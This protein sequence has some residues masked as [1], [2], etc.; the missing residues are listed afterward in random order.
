[1]RG[2]AG[3]AAAGRSMSPSESSR[4]AA[5]EALIELN[6]PRP[7]R[8]RYPIPEAEFVRVKQR[9]RTA[10]VARRT[11]PHAADSGRKTELAVAP[12]ASRA[13]EAAMEPAAAP[14]SS[15]NFA[16]IPATGWIPPDC[17]MAVGPNHILLSVNSSLAIYS[18]TGGPALLQR[19]LTQWFSNA[20]QDL[21]IFDPKAL[22]DQHAGRWVLLAV[23]FRQNPNRSVFLLSVSAGSDPLGSWRNY[24][25]DAM[26][27]GT[28]ATNNWADYPG[29]GVDAQALYVT[30][31]MF[32]FGGNFQYAKIRVIPKAGPY[33]GGPAPF[34][35]FVRMRNP[36]NTM[37]FTIQP[38]HTFGAPMVEYLVN[39][40]FP[41]GSALTLWRI[42]NPVAPTLTRADVPIGAYSLPP[43]ADQTGGPPELNTGDVRILHA[44]FRGDS[45]WAAFTT[46]RNWGAGNRASIHWVQIRAASNSLVQQGI[47]GARDFH[48]FYPAACPDNNGNMTLV[49]SRSGTSQSGS[50][51]FTG[52][53]ATD[54][55]GQLQ[56]SALLKT[57]VAH[58]QALDG[59]GRN[60]WGDYNGVAADP[61]NPRVIWFYSEFASAVNTWATWVGSVFF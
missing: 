13:F 36:D 41:S 34:F 3:R 55:A 14:V 19:T 7:Y 15:V 47:F 29:L 38:C 9:A 43:N 48:Y 5:V 60:R 51:G 56:P 2:R 1:M 23:A 58:Y 39:S 12:A 18:K 21:T 59:G 33:S 53:R 28:T 25:F 45:V 6:E 8:T 49:F 50:I 27:D 32:A 40:R 57:G 42:T 17:T 26:V 10:K 35:D 54:P 61:A 4:A 20:V 24:V 16:G 37:A 30:A 31:N 22:F 11:V 52:R 44:V 46:V